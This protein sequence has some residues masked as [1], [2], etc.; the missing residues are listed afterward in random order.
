MNG[1]GMYGMIAAALAFSGCAK[2]TVVQVK[3]PSVP[4]EGVIYALPNTVVRIQVKVDKV[5]KQD[6]PFRDYAPLF[7]PDGKRVCEKAGCEGDAVFSVQQGATFG[8]YGEPD[9]KN[10]FLVK[11]ANGRALDQNLS[12]T[13]NEAGLLSAASNSVTNRTTDI[14]VS[15]LKLAAGLGVKGAGLAGPEAKPNPAKCSEVDPSAVDSRADE[16]FLGG[17]RL[18]GPSS[19][20][21]YCAMEPAEREKLPKD[22]K[23][24]RRAS[25]AFEFRVVPLQLAREQIL[26]GQS[27]SAMEP[28]ALLPRIEAEIANREAALYLGTKK[29]TTWDGMLD[30]RYFEEDSPVPV[31]QLGHNGVC[32]LRG[33]MP[34]ESKPMPEG[35]ASS[36]CG[37][38]T[39]VSMKVSYYPAPEK[40]LFGRLTDIESGDRSFRYRIP[41]QVKGVLGEGN[42]GEKDKR[43]GIGQFAVAQFGRVISLPAGRMSK[44]VSY[45]LGFLEATG[46]L[47]TF[48][49]GTT[50]GLDSATVDALAGVGGTVLDARN[51]A[52]QNADEVTALTKQD[53]LLKLKD[54]ICTIQK[55]YNLP[56]T[57]QP[58]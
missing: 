37:G 43:Y 56:C 35:F 8:T 47:K 2:V 51:K 54:D 52:K 58:E 36:N 15:G 17:G 57:V 48:K 28:A 32:L 41:A 21:A 26:K 7:A 19:R 23:L 12:M 40:Q 53:A 10:V 6:A 4:A 20:Q 33:E 29:T 46:G 14:V 25:A 50:G 44:T 5:E 22:D 18:A 30:V 34:P 13:W 11:F 42:L 3:T 55:K 31:F 45:D 27:A 39:T 24:L 1:R 16:W 49:L 9:P 38:G